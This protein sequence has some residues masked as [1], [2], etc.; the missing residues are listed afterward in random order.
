VE[1]VLV[2]GGAGFIGSALIRHLIRETA[3]RIVNLDKLTYAGNLESLADVATHPR[4]AF[5][6]A[7]VCD[8][9]ALCRIIEQYHPDSIV[10]LAAESHVD[11]SIGEP[12]DFV[13][14]NITGTFTR[15]QE[16]RRYWEQLPSDARAGFRMVHVS[17]DEVFG[18]IAD[19]ELA[20]EQSPYRPSSPYAAS[21]AA[22]DHLVRA[23]RETYGLPVVT[24]NCCNNYGPFQFPEKLIPVAILNALEGKP[25]PVYGNGENVRDWLYVEDHVA[26]LLAVL[27]QGRIGETYCVSAQGTRSNLSVVRA[28]CELLDELAPNPRIGTRTALIRLVPDR[29]GHDFRYALD[30]SRIRN[31]LGWRPRL[32]F[33]CGLRK[34]VEWYLG[35]RDWT[36]RVLSGAYRAAQAAPGA[37]A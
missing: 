6:K 16:A 24:T 25:I 28:V 37:G 13:R 26:A 14:T 29:P 4:Y 27:R 20:R 21:K 15:L 7:D 11:R 35:H 22:A 8:A 19:G 33:A 36:G 1:T 2:T 31:D 18:S 9:R 32:D 34:T 17:T 23:W 5:A 30:A 12:G 10:H 3:L